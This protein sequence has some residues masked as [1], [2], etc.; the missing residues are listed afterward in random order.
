VGGTLL[1]AEDCLSLDTSACLSQVCNN[2]SIESPEVCDGSDLGGA[3]CQTE[4]FFGGTLS[5]SAGC[6]SL[7]TSDCTMCG[8]N[9]LDLG[10]VC[11][12]NGGIPESCA[13]LGCRSGQV[14]CAEDCQSYNYAGCYA[15]HDEDGDGL[16]DNC[17][18]CPTV[19]NLGQND[20][21]GDGLGDAC[22]SPTGGT[23]LS[24]VVTFDPFLNN[25]GS[26][27]SYGGTW[28]W[29]V[30]LLTGNATG[31]GN[32]LH[33]DTLSGAAFSVETTFHYPENPG[34]GNNWVAV[35]F[36]WQTIAGVLSAGWECTYEREVKEI[37]LYKYATTGW[38][39]QAGTTVSTSVT[40]GQWHRLRAVYSSSGIRCYYT[41]ETGA[42]GSLA[43]TDSVSVGS[44]SGKP[45]VRVYTDRANF[46]S[47]ITY[48]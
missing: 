39:M 32:Y 7:D 23:V 4:N 29:G 20:S 47:F 37:G 45:G 31:G 15:G 24:H 12:G 46:T 43:F 17:D 28:T 36:G 48:Q 8:N 42:T 38:S 13:D 11:D 22:E 14:T 41:D 3:T 6:M 2:G 16:D 35:L 30:D 1:C 34:A 18:N 33:N 9:Q 40:N 25:A 21:D 44:M 19:H 26:W 27:S 10:E 5:C